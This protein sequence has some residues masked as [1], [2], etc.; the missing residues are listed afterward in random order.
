VAGAFEMDD[1]EVVFFRDNG[2]LLRERVF[3][4]AE[5]SSII[6]ACETLVDQ[7]KSKI[8]APRVSTGPIDASASEELDTTLKW[9]RGVTDVVS[10]VETFVHLNDDLLQLSQDGRLTS[11]CKEACSAADGVVLFTEKLNL[12]RA[13]VGAAVPPHC[14]GPHWEAQA[15]HSRQIVTAMIY[16]DEAT[17]ENGCL[18]VAPGSHKL[19][20][21][22]DAEKLEEDS[23]IF[24]DAPA[25][26]VIW[27][28][29]YLAHRSR[30]NLSDK[31]RRAL[32][33]SYQPLGNQHQ[34]I[35]MKESRERFARNAA[36]LRAARERRVKAQ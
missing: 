28:G 26:S 31:D 15:P 33:Y 16:L 18:Q 8:V 10:G 17:R 5:C 30:P 3:D 34:R 29:G 36:F 22:E 23:M 9:E 24:L 21:A 19:P 25:G 6:S 1:A 11:P 32:L 2:Y 35:L 13:H 27:F 7:L 4:P 12:K 14:D 20:S